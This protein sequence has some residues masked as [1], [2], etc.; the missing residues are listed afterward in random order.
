MA[1]LLTLLSR[2]ASG[3]S[4]V[5]APGGTNAF[6]PTTNQSPAKP[7]QYAYTTHT[8][9]AGGGNVRL[10]FANWQTSGSGEQL[11]NANMQGWNHFAGVLYN[12]QFYRA[13]FGGQ[14]SGYTANGA[15]VLSDPVP[16]LRFCGPSSYG[17]FHAAVPANYR[18]GGGAPAATLGA[19]GDTYYD[20]VAKQWYSKSAGAWGGASGTNP[21]LANGYVAP[22]THYTRGAFGEYAYT[23]SDAGL[24]F[25]D[26]GFA[27]GA[28]LSA[29]AALV[30]GTVTFGQFKIV[31]GGQN[32]GWDLS[33]PG[34]DVLDLSEIGPGGGFGTAAAGYGNAQGGSFY[35]LTATTGAGGTYTGPLAAGFGN[36]TQAWGP[37]LITMTPDVATP[38]VLMAGDSITS[39]AGSSDGNGDAARAFGI[40]Q[41]LLA[42]NPVP[43]IN[44]GVPGLTAQALAGGMGQS[45]ALF[46]A[47]FPAGGSNIFMP[48]GTNDY[49]AGTPS[50]LA[51]V[52]ASIQSAMNWWKNTAGMRHGGLGTI[53]PRTT[54]TDSFATEA[55]QTPVN[56][57]F[58]SGGDVDAHNSQIL[59][60]TLITNQDWYLDLRSFVQGT[61]TRKWKVGG[62]FTQSANGTT[63]PPT[64]D[65]IHPT[66]PL[67]V[68]AAA[69]NTFPT[70]SA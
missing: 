35:A 37:S 22:V 28:A 62:G 10:A 48:I 5:A 3:A 63:F 2:T 4:L 64:A 65:G 50:A 20:R 31:N 9:P 51:S 12:G 8:T 39:G 27:R 49:A 44:W 54:S 13:T 38:W 32:Y 42:K 52:K 57:A 43:S 25:T 18:S 70:L 47:A 61:D 59:A 21:W 34:I 45:R 6:L 11:A 26:G 66:K 46:Q 55:N 53:L 68:Y 60:N 36:T 30:G 24:T 40:Y 7:V 1:R 17:V 67:M 15:F 69:N 14:G 58:S 33:V 29:A 56:A 23:G 16:G 41:R 19:D